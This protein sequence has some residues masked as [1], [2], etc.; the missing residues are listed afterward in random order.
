MA[1]DEKLV[2]VLDGGAPLGLAI[3]AGALL[4]ITLG[5]RFP[6]I[7][8]PDVVDASGAVHPGISTRPVPVL[9]ASTQR[10]G[11]L[12]GKARTE[13]EVTVV[14]ITATAQRARTYAEYT[15]RLAEQ[16]TEEQQVVGLALHGPQAV[17]TSLTGD[18]PLYR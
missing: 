18:L 15:R 9:T 2:V 8:G 16:P 1:V 4:G 6:D 17:L 10:L 7:V 13:P 3:N 14:D 11:D 12:A 5:R